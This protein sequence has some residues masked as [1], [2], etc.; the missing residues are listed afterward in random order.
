VRANF[1]PASTRVEQTFE[2]AVARLIARWSWTLAELHALPF[3]RIHYASLIRKRRPAG[4]D[5]RG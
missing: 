3:F 2:F 1:R 4:D 5:R